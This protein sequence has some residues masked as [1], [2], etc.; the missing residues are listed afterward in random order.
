MYC[1]TDNV[2][3]FLFIMTAWNDQERQN[4]YFAVL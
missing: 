3:I 1:I 2:I 4:D